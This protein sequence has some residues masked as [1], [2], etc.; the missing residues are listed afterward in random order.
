MTANPFTANTGWDSD[1]RYTA[2][3]ATDVLVSNA[4]QSFTVF[5]TLTATDTAPTV[6]PDETN[7]LLP[8]Q[9][10]AMQLADT[11]RLWL[12]SRSGEAAVNVE[13]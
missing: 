8:G 7:A 13:D 6:D 2:S 11:E 12:A 1:N 9:F 4:S 3:G 5:W 10:I